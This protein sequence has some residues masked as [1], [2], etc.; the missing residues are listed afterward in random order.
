MLPN[1]CATQSR[2]GWRMVVCCAVFRQNRSLFIW[3][4]LQIPSPSRVRSIA[5]H[6]C[7]LSNSSG[8]LLIRG[9]TVLHGSTNFLET[10]HV[11]LAQFDVLHTLKPERQLNSKYSFRECPECVIWS[12]FTFSVWTGTPNQERNFVVNNVFSVWP[13]TWNT[14]HFAFWIMIVVYWYVWGNV[15]FCLFFHF[16]NV[17]NGI[18]RLVARQET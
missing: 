18:F 16:G 2:W 10:V 6:C 12:T 9:F 8:M 11:Q 17:C 7:W 5:I 1:P 14:R 15:L 3:F 13:N 4:R